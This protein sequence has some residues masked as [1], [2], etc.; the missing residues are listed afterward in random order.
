[1]I[2]SRPIFT[3]KTSIVCYVYL[4]RKKSTTA[5]GHLNVFL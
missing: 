3:K 1:M 4:N 5:I 2:I